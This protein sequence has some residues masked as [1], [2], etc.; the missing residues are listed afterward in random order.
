MEMTHSLVK[1]SEVFV[2]KYTIPEIDLSMYRLCGRTI[3]AK[4]CFKRFIERV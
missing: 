4:A 2:D 3:N 1:Y